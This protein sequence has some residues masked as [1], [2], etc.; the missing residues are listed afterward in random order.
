M[1]IDHLAISYDNKLFIAVD[2]SGDGNCLYRALVESDL[3]PLS[4]SKNFR[5]NLSHR[6]KILLKNGS[7][8]GHHIQN[9]FN[10]NEKSIEC[11]SIENYI[12]CN[13][14]VNGKWGSTFEIIC[15]SII[16][17]VR[18]ISIANMSGGFKVSDTLFLLR[19]YEIVNDNSVIFDRY[20]YIHI[21][22]CTKLP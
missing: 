8:H 6:T 22:I 14:G 16:Y 13:M 4:D 17:C 7:S 15:V 19:A 5:S 12:D 20:I 18:I 9:Y 11:G 10:N 3:I 1:N 2:V 21:V